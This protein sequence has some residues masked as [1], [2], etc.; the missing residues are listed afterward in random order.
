[1]DAN[2]K[3]S[4]SYQSKTFNGYRGNSFI[5]SNHFFIYLWNCLPFTRLIEMSDMVRRFLT[6]GENAG[7]FFFR[8]VV[9]CAFVVSPASYGGLLKVILSAGR[10][11]SRLGSTWQ[12]VK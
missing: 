11:F 6:R 9:C 7:F 3:V 2:L 5:P 10:E 12:D 4:I 8:L 1:M